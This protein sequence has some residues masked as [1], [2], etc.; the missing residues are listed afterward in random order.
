[1]QEYATY[2]NQQKSQ[3]KS[4]AWKTAKKVHIHK[5]NLYDEMLTEQIIKTSERNLNPNPNTENPQ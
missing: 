1:M 2:P 5:L 3:I 4:I